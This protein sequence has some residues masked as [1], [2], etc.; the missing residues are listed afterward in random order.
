M[1][2]FISVARQCELVELNRSSYYYKAGGEDELTLELLRLIDEEYTRHPFL[3]SR[4]MVR[5]LAEKGHVVNRKRIQRLYDLLGIRAIY[6]GPKLSLGAKEHK[7][8]PYLLKD[9]CISAPNQVWSTDLTYIRLKQGFVYLMAIIDW[10]SRYVVDWS[11]STTLEAD[12]CVETLLRSLK[13]QRCDIFNTDQGAQFTAH[14]FTEVLKCHGIKISM[15][16]RGRALDNIFVER[17]W[18]SVK[19]ECI[20]LQEFCTVKQVETALVNYFDYYNHHRY[21]QSLDY[22]TPVYVHNKGKIIV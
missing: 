4:K 21:H 12:F 17:L 7:V 18:R 13:T 16:G 9:I 10:Y 11:L 2:K 19:Y 8:Y 5:Y 1:H 14:A 20:Y 3:G 6:P 15:D 22:L